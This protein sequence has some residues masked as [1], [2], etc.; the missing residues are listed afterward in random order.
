MD[1]TLVVRGSGH[2]CEFVD[3]T[4]NEEGS[5]WEEGSAELGLDEELSVKETWGRVEWGSRDR[6]VHEVGCSNCVPKNE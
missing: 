6:R 4:E 3:L 1:L 5:P 2:P